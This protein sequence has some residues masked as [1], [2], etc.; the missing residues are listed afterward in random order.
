MRLNLILKNKIKRFC[1]VLLQCEA[2]LFQKM[3]KF[4]HFMT[5]TYDNYLN[6]SFIELN[7]QLKCIDI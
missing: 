6:F 7:T 2:I 4:F 1:L 3:Q 5:Q